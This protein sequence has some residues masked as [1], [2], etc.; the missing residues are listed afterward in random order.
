M[1]PWPCA[2]LIA[3]LQQSGFANASQ[4]PALQPDHPPLI[5]AYPALPTRAAADADS[6]TAIDAAADD[7]P[8]PFYGRVRVGWK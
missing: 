2:A 3:T 5:D 1:R 4:L 7:Q 6:P 8:F